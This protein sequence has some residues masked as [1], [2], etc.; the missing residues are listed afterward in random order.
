[1]AALETA[2]TYTNRPKSTCQGSDS[3]LNPLDRSDYVVL[4]VGSDIKKPTETGHIRH[5]LKQNQSNN[6]NL[7]DFGVSFKSLTK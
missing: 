3:L 6:K 5:E 4:N 1:M 7:H 2:K